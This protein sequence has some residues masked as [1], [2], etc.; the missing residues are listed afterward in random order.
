MSLGLSDKDIQKHYQSIVS[1]AETEWMVLSY[2]KGTNDLRVQA[3][4]DS[5]LEEMAEEFMESRLVSYFAYSHSRYGPSTSFI[6]AVAEG[7]GWAKLTAAYCAG[8]S[9]GLYG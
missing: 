4:G 1:G 7:I 9:T 2:D 8:F 5:G 6:V 3:T